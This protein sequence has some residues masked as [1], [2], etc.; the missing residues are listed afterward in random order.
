MRYEWEGS[1]YECKVARKMIDKEP[2]RD[3]DL[4]TYLAYRSLNI[5]SV[6]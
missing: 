5:A 2:G 6:S 1:G 4:R 3:E